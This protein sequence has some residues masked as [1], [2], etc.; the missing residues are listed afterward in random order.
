MKVGDHSRKACGIRPRGVT[1]EVAS[2][3]I[4]G[5]M[6]G[7]ASLKGV[8]Q[9]VS[10]PYLVDG[11]FRPE[12]PLEPSYRVQRASASLDAETPV[13]LDR[14]PELDLLH[15]HCV[16]LHRVLLVVELLGQRQRGRQ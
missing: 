3:E 11:P 10:C 8:E 9:E 6:I 4:D 5:V 1:G 16:A 12:Q 13:W 15:S 7:G 2:C 14:S